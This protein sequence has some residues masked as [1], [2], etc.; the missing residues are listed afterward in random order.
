MT[1]KAEQF[2][3]LFNNDGQCWMTA[4]GRYWD[5]VADEM[6]ADVYT[7][8]RDDATRLTFPDG[9]VITAVGDAWD[10]GFPDCWCWAGCPRDGHDDGRCGAG[11]A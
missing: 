1:T 11:E 10:H 6:G 7:R 5:T 4:D 9:S 8:H 2:A 3:A